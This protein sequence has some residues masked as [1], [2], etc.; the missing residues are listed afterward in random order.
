MKLL[1]LA[2]IAATLAA[3]PAAKPDPKA[4]APAAE[5]SKPPE[6]A[7]NEVEILKLRLAAKDIQAAQTKHDIKGFQEEIQEPQATQ[8][9]IV[10]AACKE[11]GIPQEKIQTECGYELGFDDKDKP[12]TRDGKPVTPRVWKAIPAPNPVQSPADKK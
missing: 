6:R 8:A 4:T 11:L 9:G 10:I 1:I 7:F 3:Q 5:T 2:A 12:I